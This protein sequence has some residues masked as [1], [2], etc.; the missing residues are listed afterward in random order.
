MIS[1]RC[2]ITDRFQFP[3]CHHLAYTI[4]SSVFAPNAWRGAAL[5]RAER[6]HTFSSSLT[7][8]FGLPPARKNIGGRQ[9]RAKAAPLQA[10][11]SCRSSGSRLQPLHRKFASRLTASKTTIPSERYRSTREAPPSA[12]FTTVNRSRYKRE[13][14]H[15]LSRDLF[16]R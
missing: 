13:P 7:P 16:A 5:D 8:C 1:V 12:S 15:C 4:R 10:L 9:A 6:P 11:Q 14:I 2:I 3:D